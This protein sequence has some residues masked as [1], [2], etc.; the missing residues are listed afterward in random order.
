MVG[1]FKDYKF[2][3]ITMNEVLNKILLVI[4]QQQTAINNN[5][6]VIA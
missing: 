3:L 4:R 5:V 2:L 6:H 1:K